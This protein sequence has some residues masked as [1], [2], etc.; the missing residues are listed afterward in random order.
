[1]FQKSDVKVGTREYIEVFED[2]EKSSSQNIRK[3]ISTNV[4]KQSEIILEYNR[5]SFVCTGCEEAF[6]TEEEYLHHRIN[7]HCREE[8]ELEEN[9]TKSETKDVSPEVSEK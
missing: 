6:Y 2:Q 9:P 4:F 7:Q 5:K 1:M 3:E 8:A